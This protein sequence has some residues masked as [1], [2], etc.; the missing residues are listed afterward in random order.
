MDNWRS[1]YPK[2]P[3]AYVGAGL[4]AAQQLM[5]AGPAWA[6]K[7]SLD[8]LAVRK[9]EYL[10]VV[11]VIDIEAT[12]PVLWMSLAALSD[13]VL[14]FSYGLP[15]ARPQVT[16]RAQMTFGLTGTTAGVSGP[17]SV[18]VGDNYVAM[19]QPYRGP[20]NLPGIR[21][22]IP[23]LVRTRTRGGPIQ[24]SGAGA[25]QV[26]YATEVE[27]AG[28][29]PIATD[30]PVSSFGHVFASG[31]DASIDAYRF[32][33]YGFYT[34]YN[35]WGFYRLFVGDTRSRTI[36]PVDLPLPPDGY[37]HAPGNVCGLNIISR[38]PGRLFALWLDRDDDEFDR[39]H[40][41]STGVRFKAWPEPLKALV[42]DDYGLN[43]RMED[44]A[45]L[46]PHLYRRP[47]RMIDPDNSPSII[48]YTDY[49]TGWREAVSEHV[50]SPVGGGRI[51]LV[52]V[53]SNE[54]DTTD[55]IEPANDADLTR[56][57][58]QAPGATHWGFY[59]SDA[60]GKNFAKKPWPLDDR[61]GI[62]D[63]LDTRP[64]SQRPDFNGMV[65]ANTRGVEMG[66]AS[67]TAGP[68]SFFVVVR[69]FA[70]TVPPGQNPTYTDFLNARMRVLWTVDYGD[71]WSLSGELPQDMRNAPVDDESGRV[72]LPCLTF[73]VV[74]PYGGTE[75]PGLLVAAVTRIGVG[76]VLWRTDA[77]FSYFTQAGTVAHDVG[78]SSNG[79]RGANQAALFVGSGSVRAP[80]RPGYPEFDRP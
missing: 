39:E 36:V 31:Y 59:I 5:R 58:P 66:A 72:G 65:F 22:L 49:M 21:F 32:G 13:D 71:S 76:V 70:G 19:Q 1:D 79:V 75:A 11:D 4:G 6:R 28:T 44:L 63:L 64:L 60:D 37:D 18:Y 78:T 29:L 56:G 26:I 68:G 24:A 55:A 40:R 69:Y 20:E 15:T 25:E 30:S 80:V 43:W 14:A 50:A 34:D 7:R 54:Y 17:F 23:S 53:S 62:I 35:T 38:A 61:P 52:L 2:R 46:T 48:D 27:R 12:R 57:G 33:F 16:S 3:T 51:A 77:R 73:T 47:Y 45:E 8:G 74:K 42:S 41:G 9:G 67:M 10:E